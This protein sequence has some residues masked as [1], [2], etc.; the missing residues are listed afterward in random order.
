MINQRRFPDTFLWGGA[1]AAFQVE[2]AWEEDGKGPTTCDLI[3]GGK[4]LKDSIPKSFPK[5]SLYYKGID[6]Y[7]RYK[8]DIALLKEMG[9][10]AYRLSICWARIFPKGIETEP[11]ET[12]LQFYDDVLDELIRSGIEPVVTI[13]HFDLPLYL[14][15]QYGGWRDRRLVEY[16]EHY[17][18][19]IFR[20]YKDKVKYWMTFNEINISLKI[21]FVG[22]GIRFKEGENR[23]QVIYQALH[24]QF[25]ASAKAVKMGHE[26]NPDFKIG[27]ML[28]GHI[29]YPMTSNPKDYWKAYREDNDS[30]FCADVQAKGRYPQ[31][32]W[33]EWEKK[34]IQIA[35]GGDDLD[36][37][38]KNT[39]DFIGISYYASKCTSAD[40]E[41]QKNFIEGN[42]FDTLPNP[43]LEKSEWGWQMDPTGLRILLNQLNDRYGKP[44]FIVENGL[45][46]RDTVNQD[47]T[48]DDMYRIDY[49][50]KHISS[51][52]D[53]LDDGVDVIGYL[54]WG[55][56]DLVSASNCLMSKRY[57]TV[58]VD[59][60]DEGQ[61]TLER[62]KKKSFEW[63]R[64]VIEHNGLN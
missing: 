11:N 37:I 2:G 51:V 22:G 41:M 23:E 34:N 38:E 16:Y 63:Y 6:F 1:S 45:G 32:M 40:P 59:L 30:L 50:E 62:R 28:A 44:I 19:T 49:L 36:I 17:C 47:G 54:M 18:E 20:R 55:I 26:I 57:G 21:P 58:Y 3:K 31:R 46:A 35:M 43:Y 4:N 42:I 12:G 53:A 24:H 29:T 14:S 48:I 60:D 27:M 7:H 64:N 13:N 33:N 5:T 9:V 10:K 8:E 61:G 52:A 39:A 56:I 15:E 25:L